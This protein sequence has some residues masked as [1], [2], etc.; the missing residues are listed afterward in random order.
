MGNPGSKDKALTRALGGK[1]VT[2]EVNLS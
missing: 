1:K 2:T